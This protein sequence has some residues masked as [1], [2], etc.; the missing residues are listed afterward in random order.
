MHVFFFY[1]GHYNLEYY[2]QTHF[3]ILFTL[4]KLKATQ[5]YLKDQTK[6]Q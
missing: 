3:L 6:I 5:N 4:K 1:N 2:I